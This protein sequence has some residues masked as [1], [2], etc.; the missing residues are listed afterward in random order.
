MKNSED[1]PHPSGASGACETCPVYHAS[2]L[3]K[4]GVQ[5]NGAD[6]IVALAG[7]PNT[8]KSTVFNALTGLK[9]HTG[10]W[11]GKTV[12]RAEGGFSYRDTVFR[13]VDLPGVYSLLSTSRDEQI[14]RDFVLFGRPDVT[15]V[16][17]DASRLE[18]SLLLA[19]QIMEITSQVVICVNL[20]DEAAK[21]GI[22]IDTR[23]LS[24]ELGVPVVLTAARSKEGLVELLDAIH[25]V[26]TGAIECSPKLQFSL[27]SSIERAITEL[28]ADIRRSYPSLPNARWVALRLL[29]GD[30]SIEEAL[31]DGSLGMLASSDSPKEIILP[32]L[33]TGA[34]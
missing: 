23:T 19:V 32:V 8:G 31:N 33:Q 14:A 2:H 34:A 21:E 24:R 6:Y 11:P 29:E 3:K 28:E 9:Q 13:L 20:A 22:T 25:G 30:A 26:A 15:V 17:T 5:T 7:N 27:P 10:N 12:A 16:V 18:R 1:K 4:M